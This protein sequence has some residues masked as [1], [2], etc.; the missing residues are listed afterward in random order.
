LQQPWFFI[1]VRRLW[2]NFKLFYD[3][4]ELCF[5]DGELSIGGGVG[6]I[7]VGNGEGE[8]IG[9]AEVT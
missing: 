7:L 4:S 1:L 9:L 2:A 3:R 5:S 6:V 8:I